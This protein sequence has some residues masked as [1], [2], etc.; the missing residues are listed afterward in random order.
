MFS[1]ISL[2]I[3]LVCLVSVPFVKAVSAQSVTVSGRITNEQGRGIGRI[4]V[5][6]QELD[7]G[8]VRIAQTR[9]DGSYAFTDVQL[10]SHYSVMPQHRLYDFAPGIQSFGLVDEKPN[11]NFIAVRR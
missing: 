6:L 11:V 4:T 7:I 3:L 1:R 2:L 10:Y 5:Y 8:T 9:G